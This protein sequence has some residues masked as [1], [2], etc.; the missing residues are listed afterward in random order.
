[1]EMGG[2]RDA[3]TLPLT[4]QQ[5]ADD[6]SH[7]Y[8]GVESDRKYL[9]RKYRE[10]FTSALSYVKILQLGNISGASSEDWENFLNV[11]LPLC[12]KL[13]KLYLKDNSDLKVDVAVIANLCLGSENT[14]TNLNLGNTACFGEAAAA[15]T[16]RYRAL[17]MLNLEGSNVVGTIR[18]L[19]AA[20]P[21]GCWIRL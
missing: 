4:P 10:V 3:R 16:S 2:H 8:F 20:L 21:E 9:P 19:K 18:D 6:A 5:F 1:M 12:T 7:M 14:L 17:T 15:L 13:E 11:A